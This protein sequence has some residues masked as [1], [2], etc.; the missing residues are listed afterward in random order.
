MTMHFLTYA[1]IPAG[2]D[3]V[4]GVDEAM[5]P[6]GCDFP[7]APWKKYLEAG[8]IAAMA[9]CYK[10]KPTN[11]AKLAWEMKD[12]NGGT[13][14]IDEKGLYCILTCNRN[15]RWDWY[16]IGGR[17][18]RFLPH[19]QVQAKVLLRKRNLKKLLPHDFITP[20]GEWHSQ[21][22]YVSTGW[23]VGHIVHEPEEQ[24]FKGF[25]QALAKWPEHCVVCVDRHC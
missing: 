15:T 19:N 8:E 7:V 18:D 25:K 6:F 20:D 24:W 17:W 1:F 10:T 5:R 23:F 14:G 11:L 2:S 13:G 22:Q 9:N 21:S 3:I 16:E 12:W 4:D